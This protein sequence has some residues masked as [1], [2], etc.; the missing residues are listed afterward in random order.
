[1][2]CD[3][4]TD[5]S[6]VSDVPNSVIVP[7]T[8]DGNE[9]VESREHRVSSAELSEAE[10]GTWLWTKKPVGRTLISDWYDIKWYDKISNR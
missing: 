5:V 10:V 2:W 1:M 6:D 3:D 8:G 4:N 9:V 7:V